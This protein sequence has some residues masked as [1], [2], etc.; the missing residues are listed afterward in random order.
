MATPSLATSPYSLGS[1]VLGSIAVT[2]R[3]G[4]V[5]KA[6]S[7][8]DVLLTKRVVQPEMSTVSRT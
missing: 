2:V 6:K 4:M 3:T 1:P 8:W 5:E 7:S